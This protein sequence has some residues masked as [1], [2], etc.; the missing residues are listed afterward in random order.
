MLLAVI[1]PAQELPEV[2]AR[3]RIFLLSAA[4]IFW[5]GM[6]IRAF[7]PTSAVRRLQDEVAAANKRI[8]DIDLNIAFCHQVREEAKKAK[9]QKYAQ[10]F[11]EK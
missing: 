9:V 2:D 8:A 7:F 10:V 1:W 4:I 3:V 11:I 6:W 5:L